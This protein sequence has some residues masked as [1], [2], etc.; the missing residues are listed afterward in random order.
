MANILLL[1]PLTC[2]NYAIKQDG[3]IVLQKL[4]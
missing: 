4:R 2:L 3:L 1:E